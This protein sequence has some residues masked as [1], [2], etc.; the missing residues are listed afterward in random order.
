MAEL[1]LITPIEYLKGVGPQKADVLKKELQVFTI[2][3]LL[4]QYPFRYIDRT[5]FHKIRKL[6]PDMMAAQVLGRLVSLQLV[7]EKRTKRLVGSFKD[8][9]GSM[10]LVWFQ[11]IPWLQKSLKVGSAYIIYGK[12]S[13]FNGQLSIT[14]P[15][16]DLYNPQVKQIG[17][18]SLQPVYSSTEKLKKFN[19]DT[20]G[21]QRL[22]Q[23][24]LETVFRSIDESLPQDVLAKHGLISRQQAF[25][26]IH[27]PSDQKELNQA[28]K[29]IKF[30]ELFFIQLKLL[31][32]KQL[33]TPEPPS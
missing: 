8:E 30:E 13:E 27:F 24:A 23:T 16:M 4:T 28:I 33:N 9:T 17:N 26:S 1:R 12:P 22:Q 10:E 29:R 32:N 2:G 3:D 7:G 6:H 20:K 11:S 15:E 21:I 25:A 14:H 31:N 18:M 5:E 19:L